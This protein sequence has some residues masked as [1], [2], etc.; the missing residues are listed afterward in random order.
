MNKFYSNESNV[1]RV[2]VSLLIF[3]LRMTV[4]DIAA[5]YSVL[6]SADYVSCI[7]VREFFTPLAH[8]K[9]Q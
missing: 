8:M 3:S 5:K 9:Y 1:K 2:Y 7:N 6:H 4:P